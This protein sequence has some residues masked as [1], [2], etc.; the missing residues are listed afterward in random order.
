MKF[1]TVLAMLN[2]SQK[3]LMPIF[4]RTLQFL[5]S[6]WSCLGLVCTLHVT[7]T[8]GSVS[9]LTQEYYWVP[10]G[11]NNYANMH[12]YPIQELHA[13]CLIPCCHGNWDKLS[14][15]VWSSLILKCTLH[16][17][18]TYMYLLTKNKNTSQALTPF[19]VH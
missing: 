7:L 8:G 15:P 13:L 1:G 4:H 3:S 11:K 14:W 18:I 10:D 9:L 16:I 19:K 6:T 2:F 17:Q 12:Q 5:V